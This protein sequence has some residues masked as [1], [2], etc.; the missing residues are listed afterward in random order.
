[1]AYN[2]SNKGLQRS[3][4]EAWIEASKSQTNRDKKAA[5]LILPFTGVRVNTYIHIHGPSWFS[6]TDPENGITKDGD[7]PK[8]MIPSSDICTKGDG[9]S[10]CTKCQREERER[11]TTKYDD[12][13]GIPLIES[14]KNWNRGGEHDSYMEEKLD[15]L[16]FCKD[17]F[18]VTE[19]D[20]GYEYPAGG[21]TQSTINTWLKQIASDAGLGLERGYVERRAFDEPVPDVVPHDMRGTFI[22]QLIRNNMQ[23]TKLTKY[24]GHNHVSSLQPYEMRVAQETDSNE[25]LSSM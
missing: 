2:R 4:L 1:M 23:R 13:R 12:E 24:T 15:L 8:I 25:F 22:M 14:W 21:I 19:E 7:H 5:G 9:Q 16:G 17:Y 11:F 3:S 6:W 20:Y 10:R 18:A